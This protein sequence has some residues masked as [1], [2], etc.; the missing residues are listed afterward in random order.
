MHGSHCR[1]ENISH[2]GTWLQDETFSFDGVTTVRLAGQKVHPAM[3]KTWRKLRSEEPELF[4]GLRLWQQPSANMDGVLWY[5]QCLLDASQYK[6]LIRITD[7]LGTAWTDQAKERAW[8]LHQVGCPVAAKCTPLQQPTDTHFAKPAKDA[9][10]R[11]KELLREA[12]RLVAA[13]TKQ[14]V[15]F[16]SGAREIVLVAQTMHTA[17]CKLNSERDMVISSCRATGWLAYRPD[18]TGKMVPA[19]ESWARLHPLGQGRISQTYLSGRF[20]FLD[21]DGRPMLPWSAKPGG[22]K[23]AGEEKEEAEE[24]EDTKLPLPAWVAKEPEP[25]EQ[26]GADADAVL[27]EQLAIEDYIDPGSLEHTLRQLMHPS[28]RRNPEV[29]ALAEKLGASKPAGRKACR[30]KPSSSQ[31]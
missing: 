26:P 28:D 11:Q 27:L 9:A 15:Q 31:G 18:N 8:L 6:Q 7:C 22:K 2:D 17:M 10:R 20:D 24:D 30:K 21:D 16:K 23:P 13:R 4:K 1:L 5:W 29:E 3:M 12:M 19:T 25:L 14:P